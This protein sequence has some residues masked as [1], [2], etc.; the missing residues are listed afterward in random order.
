MIDRKPRAIIQCADV[1][2]ASADGQW[3][4]R[5]AGEID[6]VNHVFRVNQN[7]KPAQA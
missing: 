5:I 3:E 1:A 2:D 7:I 6:A 4:F